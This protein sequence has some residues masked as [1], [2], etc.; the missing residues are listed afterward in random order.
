M[1]ELAQLKCTVCH[2]GDPPLADAE[3]FRL[4][5]ETPR[6]DIKPVNEIKQLERVFT[7]KNFAQAIFFVTKVGNVADEEH[8]HPTIL[9][10]YDQVTLRWWTHK[11]RG[12]HMNDF[13]M[14]AKADA[15]YQALTTS[16]YHYV[17]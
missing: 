5:R 8:H 14:A 15:I 7:F 4:H 12:L 17:R 10:E 3:I 9:I 11:V 16:G 1:A 2:R 13:I 6:W